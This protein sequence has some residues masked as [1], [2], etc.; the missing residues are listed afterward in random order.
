MLFNVDPM[1]Y[2]TQ[3]LGYQPPQPV[4]PPQQPGLPN[5]LEGA[6]PPAGNQVS[7]LPQ[8]VPQQVIPPSTE[9]PQNLLNQVAIQ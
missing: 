5:G 9:Q 2:L 3:V 1:T 8:D 7:G 4:V 6:Q